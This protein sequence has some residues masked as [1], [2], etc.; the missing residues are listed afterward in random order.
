MGGK[1]AGPEHPSRRNHDQLKAKDLS[2]R[3][4]LAFRIGSV[5]LPIAALCLV[6]ICCRIAGFGGYPPVISDVGDDGARHWYSTHRLGTDTF[7]DAAG[8]LTGGMRVMHFTTPKPPNTVR[9]A[10]LGGSAV[11]GFP[12]PLPLTNGSFLQAMLEDLWSGNREVEVL[13]FGATAVASFPVMCFLDDVL[14]HDVDLVVVMCGNNEF[15]G[16]YGVSSLYI[17]GRTPMGMRVFRWVRS[18]ALIQ[19][20]TSLWSRSSVPSG[21]L[22]EQMAT[23]QLIDPDD[24]VRRAAANALRTHLTAMVRRCRARDVPIIVCTVPTNEQGIA[25]IGPD[26]EEGLT[27]DQRQQ[28]SKALAASEELLPSQPA[29][30]AR[31]AH[32]ALKLYDKHARAHFVMGRALSNL[33]RKDEALEAYIKARDFDAM[34]W[35]ATSLARGTVMSAIEE[36]AIL[37]DMEHTFRAT[38]P[39]GAI[40]WELMDDHV[41]MSLAGQ[42]LFAKTILS[43]LTSISGPLHVD[44]KDLDQLPD[45]RSYADRLGHSVYTDYVSATR[46]RTLFGISFMKSSNLAAFERAENLCQD[47]LAGMSEIDRRAVERWRDP[48]LHGAAD[49]PLTFVVGVYRMLDGDYEIAE[50]LFRTAE[51]TVPKMS[52][53]RLQLIWYILKCRRHLLEEPELEDQRLCRE[54]IH[55]G[56]ML[57]RYGH[58]GDPEVVRYLGLAYNLMGN[59]TAA[60]RCLDEAV[61]WVSGGGGWEV[62]AALADS[63]VQIGRNDAAR[64]LLKLAAQDRE[65]RE[66]ARRMLQSLDRR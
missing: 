18:L 13:N 37:C 53:P 42:A 26:Y 66:P 31:L 16:A 11:Q 48:F 61:R 52:L 12:Q 34:P 54:A 24:S 3:K 32:E 2:K 51:A 30:S 19:W 40:G 7:F 55:I 62:V 64:Q 59:H 45:W 49:L 44:P 22:M 10:L 27:E 47:L 46:I 41:H 21:T 28:L 29:E 5:L 15:Y 50:G 9:I 33:E 56:E 35:R 57:N 36:G 63:Y 39:S 4:K 8:S 38:S 1:V 23:E 43:T 60:V 65:M 58:E 20:L 25:P 17:A 14:E 6:E